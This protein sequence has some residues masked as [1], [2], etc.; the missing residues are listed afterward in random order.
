VL[1]TRL[2]RW[3]SLRYWRVLFW[4]E[5]NLLQGRWRPFYPD[6]Y[7]MQRDPDESDEEFEARSRLF[8]IYVRRQR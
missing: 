3:I 4:L 1:R 8:D 6:D 7:V 5:D 2:K